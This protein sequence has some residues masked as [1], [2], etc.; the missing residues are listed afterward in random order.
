VDDTVGTSP[1][2]LVIAASAAISA[3]GS[4]LTCS[5]SRSRAKFGLSNDRTEAV[6]ARKM[7]S[8]SPASASTAQ[9]R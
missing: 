1:T 4:C 6:S 5:C 8:N 3:S 9:R 2:R 7:K